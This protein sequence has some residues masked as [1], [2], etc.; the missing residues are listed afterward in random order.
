MAYNYLITSDDLL[1]AKDKIAEIKNA[2]DPSYEELSYDLDEDT[3]SDVVD[4][5][6]KTSANLNN[7]NEELELIDNW[8]DNK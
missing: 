4:E 8:N 1:A 7:H 3:L 6:S 5:L 2:L